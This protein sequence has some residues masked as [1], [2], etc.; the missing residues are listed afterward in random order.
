MA[1][2]DPI[3]AEEF[4]KV[5]NPFKLVCTELLLRTAKLILRSHCP[6]LSLVHMFSSPLLI[7]ATCAHVVST[8]TALNYYHMTDPIKG[9]RATKGEGEKI[10]T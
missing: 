1:L 9:T 10:W 7:M 8:F 5:K 6:V 2:T 3:K 4:L